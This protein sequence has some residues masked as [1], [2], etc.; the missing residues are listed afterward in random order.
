M[1]LLA[2]VIVRRQTDKTCHEDLPD[3]LSYDICCTGLINI[4]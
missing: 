1:S 4:W 3:Q 2:C